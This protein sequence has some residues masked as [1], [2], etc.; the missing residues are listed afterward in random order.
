MAAE[1]QTKGK[2]NMDIA[3]LR[4]MQILPPGN[5]YYFHDFC[6]HLLEMRNMTLRSLLIFHLFFFFLLLSELLNY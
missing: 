5:Y 3:F 1:T 2:K 6:H 4:D